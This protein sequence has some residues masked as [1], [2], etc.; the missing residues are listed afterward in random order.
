ML[1]CG[2]PRPWDMKGAPK[3]PP[4]VQYRTGTEVG[5]DVYIW[6]CVDGEHVVIVQGSSAMCGAS[7]P[8]MQRGACGTKLSFEDTKF[9]GRHYSVPAGMRWP[10]S[11][12]ARPEEDMDPA[13]LEAGAP[14]AGRD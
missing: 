8:R 7:A 4:D 2:V 14:D 5:N 3:P 10:G 12:P 1:A 11:P 13:E 6:N 9:D